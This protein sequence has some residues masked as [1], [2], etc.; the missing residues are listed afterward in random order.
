MY[1]YTDKIIDEKFD[2]LTAEQKAQVYLYINAL[3]DNPS[4]ERLTASESMHN[5]IVMISTF[6]LASSLVLMA[7]PGSVPFFTATAPIFLSIGGLGLCLAAWRGIRVSDRFMALMTAAFGV[8]LMLF[9][10]VLAAGVVVHGLHPIAASAFLYGITFAIYLST[11]L[12]L[13]GVV[14][15]LQKPR[16]LSLG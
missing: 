11:S 16:Y 14:V 2:K 9:G 13:Y 4:Q 12:G 10:P 1:D 7:N 15:N 5:H 6:P 3:N 8:S